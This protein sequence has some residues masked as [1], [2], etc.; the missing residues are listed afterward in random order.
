VASVKCEPFRCQRW[1]T[2]MGADGTLGNVIPDPE[3]AVGQAA[4]RAR[5]SA[6]ELDTARSEA[7]S[8]L[9]FDVGIVCGG[10]P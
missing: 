2:A 3:N 8:R 7:G 9:R 10:C 4:A 1:S 6:G 5:A